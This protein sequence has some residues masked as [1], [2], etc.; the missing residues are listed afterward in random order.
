MDRAKLPNPSSAQRTLV[1]RALQ[2]PSA[3]RRFDSADDCKIGGSTPTER[4]VASAPAQTPTPSKSSAS[5]TVVNR[6]LRVG[7]MRRFDSAEYFGSSPPRKK[8][9]N[10][11]DKVVEDTMPHKKNAA[12]DLRRSPGWLYLVLALSVRHLVSLHA[13]SGEGTPPR[14]GDYEAHRHWM[15]VTTSL[16]PSEWYTYDVEYWG[17][18]YPPLMAYIEWVLGMVSRVYEPAS[19]ALD[20]SRGYETVTHKAFMRATVVAMD[21]VACI[22]VLPKTSAALMSPAPI[23][24]DHGHFQYN[25]L[26]LGLTLW[27]ARM[28]SQRPVAAALC[29]CLALNSKQ[30]ALYYAPAVFF[31]FLA[32]SRRIVDVVK[33]GIVVI[34]VFTV[35]WAPLAL[36]G[37]ALQALRRCFPVERG[38]FE[39]KV[40]NFW[41]AAQVLLRARDRYEAA[42]LVKAAAGL[43][44]LAA[45][46]VPIARC[47]RRADDDEGFLISLHLSS[48]AFFLFSYHVHEKAILVPLAP[49]LLIQ[50]G[51]LAMYRDIFSFAAAVSISPLL[52][53]E[54]LAPAYVATLVLFVTLNQ[55]RKI[56]AR[57]L[58]P[59][60]VAS[61]CT[62]L[63][64]PP[65]R[66][67]D[68]YPALCALF[69]ALL[70]VLAFFAISAIELFS[71]LRPVCRPRAPLAKKRS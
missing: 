45:F 29:F 7:G 70:F 32:R 34:A 66:Y 31:E 9:A 20:A 4:K 17:L 26:P 55:N 58:V 2:R 48:L 44:A 35:V 59:V 6:A 18:D 65:R 5:K 46:P 47:W 8:E 64:S 67:P 52:Y 62:L 57:L 12:M 40:A 22:S 49:L 38:I 16:P 56:L 14:Y 27:M 23:L 30:T 1:S 3:L 61:A 13:Y 60:M 39:D 37:C 19:V 25:C 28:I 24:V 21:A 53:F 71:H 36:Q 68:L 33:V 42:D 50:G 63:V 54:G 51:R 41:Y 69:F 43:T 10:V 11:K 15:E